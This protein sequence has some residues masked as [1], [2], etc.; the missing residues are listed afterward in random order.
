[1]YITFA[2]LNNS[3]YNTEDI[4][5]IHLLVRRHCSLYIIN[6]G[7]LKT[8]NSYRQTINS[9]RSVSST[10]F[11]DLLF[12]KVTPPGNDLSYRN[13][14]STLNISP[15][16][17]PSIRRLSHIL[18]HYV[19]RQRYFQILF[20]MQKDLEILVALSQ[21]APNLSGAISPSTLS[22]PS[23]LNLAVSPSTVSSSGN[24]ITESFSILKRIWQHHFRS[25]NTI[26]AQS[27]RLTLLALAVRV[28]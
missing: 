4:S 17:S 27:P 9:T 1:M 28:K 24:D 12:Y 5:L 21:Y 14:A 13:S 11:L 10:H 19:Q 26:P 6:I 2:V 25:P 23:L 22:S 20:D 3:L 18:A 7:K 15:S 8:L 16:L